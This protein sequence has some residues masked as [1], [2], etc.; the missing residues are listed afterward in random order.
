VPW[1]WGVLGNVAWKTKKNSTHTQ[2]LSIEMHSN[3]GK[4]VSMYPCRP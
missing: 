1:G 4:S 2:D 3:E